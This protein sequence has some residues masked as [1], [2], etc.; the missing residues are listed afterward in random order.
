MNA[1]ECRVLLSVLTRRRLFLLITSSRPSCLPSSPRRLLHLSLFL[2]AAPADSIEE[3]TSAGRIW[4]LAA[5]GL[6]LSP[7]LSHNLFSPAR[8]SFRPLPSPL[9]M[10]PHHRLC[11]LFLAF[12][13]SIHSVSGAFSPSSALPH[14]SPAHTRTHLA[15]PLFYPAFWPAGRFKRSP[16]GC[17]IRRA[18]RESVRE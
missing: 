6:S 5:L 2:L 18:V 9:L 10:F 17:G 15:R 13:A 8:R 4:R 12:I 1:E 16:G 11:W 7:W 3:Q 14:A